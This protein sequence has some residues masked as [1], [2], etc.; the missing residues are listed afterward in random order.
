MRVVRASQNPEP[1]VVADVKAEVDEAYRVLR[2]GGI[3][4]YMCVSPI[5]LHL[6]DRTARADHR[7]PSGSRSTFGQPHFRKPL[8]ARPGWTLDHYEL[9]DGSDSFPYF[10]Y[11]MTKVI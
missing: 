7:F 6:S 3:F 5:L 10:L 8:L 11:I 1:E 4:L 2:P 9:G